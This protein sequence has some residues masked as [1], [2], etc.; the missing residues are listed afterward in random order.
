VLGLVALVAAVVIPIA[1]GAPDKTYTSLFPAASPVTPAPGTSGNTQVLQS[2]CAGSSY[3]SVKLQLT[4]T[5]KTVSLG[6]ADITFPANVTLSGTPTRTG[7]A[8]GAT[9]SRIGRVVSLRQLSLPKNGVVTVSVAL[10]ASATAGAAQ[11]VRSVVKQSNDFNDTG[12]DANRFS[13]PTFP[14]IRVVSCN[15]TI[16]GR[17]Y[18][19]RDQSGAFAVNANSPTSDIAKQGWTVTLQRQTGP[20]TYTNVD[21]DTSDTNG[22]YSVEGPI[23]SNFRLCVASGSADSGTAW[24]LRQVSGVTLTTGCTDITPSS[25]DSKG[26]SVANLT[27]SGASG[28]DFAVVPVT[29]LDFQG[30]E[31]AGSGNYIVTAGGDSTKLPQH[32][33]QET[34]TD[35]NGHPYFVFA[36]IN[37]CTG[38]GEIFLLEFL[39]GSVKQED[40][41]PAKQVQLVY[42]DTEPFQTFTPMP[43]C[44]QDPGLTTP[45]D[46]LTSDVL[47]DGA[48][49]CIVKGVQTAR[50]NGT[51]AGAYVDFEFW[52]YS[53][54]DGSRGFS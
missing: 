34:W 25:P 11:D 1:T 31:T 27:S 9:I 36:P 54:Y 20:S 8:S 40:L 51:L 26:L 22:L 6:S 18:H 33:V 7:G 4:N 15:A 32:Y 3:T 52:V 50:G 24:A 17:V 42:D 53:S 48:T 43:Y 28:Q 12:G 10:S 21:T 30:G 2:L 29:V 14:Q 23:G 39:S 5:A 19:D 47:P 16:T 35:G 49:S 46:L 13:D 37:A 38:C 44:L 41:G 45:T